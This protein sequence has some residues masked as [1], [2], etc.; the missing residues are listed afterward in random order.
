MPCRLTGRTNGFEPF[1]LG[2]FPSGATLKTLLV[3]LLIAISGCAALNPP[4]P[5]VPAGYVF[6]PNAGSSVIPKY[7]NAIVQGTI[8]KIT[9]EW[10]YDDPC[11]LLA[12]LTKR[13]DA[14]RAYKVKVKT[15]HGDAEFMIFVPQY[16]YVPLP[17][18]LDATFLLSKQFIL[19]LQKCRDVQGMTSAA[20]SS[21]GTVAWVLLSTKD[22]WNRDAL[23]EK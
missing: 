20:C 17:V 19:P 6:K 18:G 13:C 8:V 22:V 4:E 11:G 9:A 16:D 3:A 14:T 23:I 10:L 15:L 21:M 2:S 12:S 5:L 1:N 7:I